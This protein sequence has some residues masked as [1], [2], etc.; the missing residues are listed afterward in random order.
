MLLLLPLPALLLI[1][2]H[3]F[4][5]YVFN[6]WNALGFLMVLFFLDT[7]LGMGRSFKQGRFHSRGMR[8]MF[9]KMG[10]YALGI[11]VAHVFSNIEVDGAKL[12]W[13]QYLG[14]GVKG[15]TYLFI[16]IIEAKSIDENMRGCGMNGLPLPKSLRRG[17]T[18]FEE[19]GE[20]RSKVAPASAPE[21][22]ATNQPVEGVIQ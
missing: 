10:E 4:E 20:F 2:R 17:M 22:I 5:K 6:D 21:L 15:L 1:A 16:L 7:M 14:M 13:A 19:T 11:V 3:L 8:Q 12:P 9:R 18:D